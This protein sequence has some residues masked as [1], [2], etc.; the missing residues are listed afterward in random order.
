MVRMVWSGPTGEQKHFPVPSHCWPA[1]HPSPQLIST[2]QSF[3][4]EPHSWS[5]G[6]VVVGVQPQTFA[7]PPPPQVFLP[8]QLLPQL[9]GPPQP[10]PVGMLPQSLFAWQV[11]GVQVQTLLTQVSVPNHPPQLSGPPQPLP[12]GMLPQSLFAWQVFGV[13]PQRVASPPPPQVSLPVQV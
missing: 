12:V 11:F 4:N 7:I 6:H 9:S 1:G 2:S 8:W 3:L 5:A 13:Q 10:S